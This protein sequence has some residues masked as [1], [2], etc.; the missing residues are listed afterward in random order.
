MRPN[1]T[2]DTLFWTFGALAS[3]W[4]MIC[5]AF[6]IGGEARTEYFAIGLLG[7]GLLWGCGWLLRRVRFEQHKLWLAALSYGKASV[8]I[9]RDRSRADK[10][11]VKRRKIV[12]RRNAVRDTKRPR[13]R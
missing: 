7:A 6:R 11:R 2:A 13:R 8:P 3:L 5:V 4:F 9:G 10:S 12:S 1:Q